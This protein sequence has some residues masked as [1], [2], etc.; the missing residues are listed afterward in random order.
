MQVLCFKKGCYKDGAKTK[1]DSASIIAELP[2][3]QKA[4]QENDFYKQKENH[5]YKTEA[6]NSELKM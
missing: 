5:R 4:F 1:T 3:E 2:Q 6:T